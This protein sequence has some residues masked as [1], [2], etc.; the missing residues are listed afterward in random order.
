MRSS[1]NHYRAIVHGVV[2]DRAGQ[3]QAIQQG[4]SDTG[5]NPLIKVTQHAT[6]CGPVNV[7][8]V[9]VPPVAGRNNVGLA[10]C[11]ESHVADESLV[12]DSVSLGPIVN[13]AM[14]LPYHTSAR[15][16]IAYFRHLEEVLRQAPRIYEQKV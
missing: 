13:T 11:H 9:P 3:Y 1:Q 8:I 12:Q 15:S 2:E 14:W 4:N 16:R 7:Q 6:G 5:R 10:L